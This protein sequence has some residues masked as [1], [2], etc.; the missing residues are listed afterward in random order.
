MP[1]VVEGAWYFTQLFVNGTRRFRARLPKTGFFHFAKPPRDCP[2]GLVRY[3]NGPDH[4]FFHGED[5]RP[6][7]NLDDVKLIPYEAWYET[8]LRP[9]AIDPARRKVTFRTRGFGT[10][11]YSGDGSR[12]IVDNV[13]EALDT[14]GAWYLD[15]PTG[16]LYYLP[17]PEESPEETEVI[18]PCLETLLQFAGVPGQPVEHIHCEHLTFAHAEWDYPYDDPGSTQAACKVPGAIRFDH[19]EACVLYD[20]RIT[21]IAQYGVEVLSGSH[22]N[23]VVGCVISDMGAGGAK[24]SHEAIDPHPN[25]Q[26]PVALSVDKPMATT[27]ADN[28][29][30]DGGLLFPSAVGVWIGNAGHN[31]VLHNHIY[32]LSYSGISCGWIWGYAPSRTVNNRIEGNHV[33]HIAWDRLLHDLG[34]IY[35]LGIQPGSTIRDNYIHHVGGNGIYLDEGSSE[36]R[37]EHNLV[38][39]V[40]ALGFTLHYGR[41]NLYREN[42]VAFSA[43]GHLMPAAAE[44]HRSM[45]VTRN[46]IFWSTGT[47]AQTPWVSV[48]NWATCYYRFSRNLLWD[49]RR[50]PLIFLREMTL[51]DWQARGQ[52]LQTVVADPLF[53]D[54]HGGD[55]SLRADSPACALGIVPLDPAHAGPRLSAGRPALSR[56]A[57]GLSRHPARTAARATAPACA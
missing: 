5:L 32:N 37:V 6:W 43:L 20:C 53:T 9:T 7:R 11:G 33:H 26:N 47:F 24:V 50:H 52:H 19:A 34:G 48:E 27:I 15:R 56:L 38:H 8:H 10:G 1:E 54:P 18:A 21:H 2:D 4:A 46:L 25:C 55:F 30:H 14:P 39:D 35:T 16:T 45:I 31:L 12:Y 44:R 36:F 57:P 23:A 42:V 22:G 13:F 40:D 49:T 51:A 17:L 3:G 41:D 29:I 28:R